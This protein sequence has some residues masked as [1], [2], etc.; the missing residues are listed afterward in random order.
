MNF[1][2]LLAA[3]LLLGISQNVHSQNAQFA[4]GDRTASI[5]VNPIFAYVGNMFDQDTYNDLYISS[6]G[7]VFRKFTS[8]T[9]ANRFAFNLSLE[10]YTR[11]YLNQVESY[12]RTTAYHYLSFNYGKE[13]R[14]NFTNLSFYGGWQIGLSTSSSLYT[15]S[16]YEEPSNSGFRLTEDNSG[17]NVALT[18]GGFLGAEYYFSPNFFLGAEVNLRANVGYN[19][20]ES[21]TIETFDYNSSNILIKSTETIEVD[22]SFFVSAS[23]ANAVLFTAGFKF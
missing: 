22:D 8:P 3:V 1:K 6:G 5:I 12:D 19:F 18:F 9:K 15:Y 14:K 11:A 21:Q 20:N 10:N 7:M 13:T 4:P 2:H 16:Y 23:S 17:N